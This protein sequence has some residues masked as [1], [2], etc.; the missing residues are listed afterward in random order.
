MK[1]VHLEHSSMAS[2]PREKLEMALVYQISFTDQH[3][4]I[5]KAGSF[6]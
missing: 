1:V 2:S 6:T 4:K 3:V 5:F